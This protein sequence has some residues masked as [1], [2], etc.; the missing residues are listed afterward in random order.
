MSRMRTWLDSQHFAP[1]TFR[2]NHV[3][4]AIV[5]RVEFS[6][7]QEA[8]AFAREFGGRILRY[9]GSLIRRATPIALDP[10]AP[11][12]VGE[13][14]FAR[15]CARPRRPPRLWRGR[16]RAAPVRGRR[17]GGEA[18]PAGRARPAGCAPASGS[19]GR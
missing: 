8:D 15:R 9:P 5:I 18:P 16:G 11:R 10:A 12:L 17:R 14:A 13:A 3:D 2:Y 1:A 6:V 4:G 7:E 19:G